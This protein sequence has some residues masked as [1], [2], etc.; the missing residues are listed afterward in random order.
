MHMRS[1][2][3]GEDDRV[4]VFPHERLVLDICQG[5]GSHRQECDDYALHDVDV[6]THTPS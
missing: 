1:V 2:L 6:P 4:D 3:A 5:D